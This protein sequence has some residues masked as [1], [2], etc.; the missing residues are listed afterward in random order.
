MLKNNF[1]TQM[2]K[3]SVGLALTFSLIAGLGTGRGTAAQ[4]ETKQHHHYK[5][6]D[7]GTF[8]GPASYVN[9]FFNTLNNQGTVVGNAETTIPQPPTTNGFPCPPGQVYKAFEWQ[10]GVVHNLG[11]L[12]DGNCSDTTAINALGQVVGT[13]ET[14]SVDPLTGFNEIRAVIWN[15]GQIQNLG[16]FGGNQSAGWTINNRGQVAGF[17]LND[18]P[19]PYSMFDLPILGSSNGTQTRA[20]ISHNGK[21]EDL[22]TL[23]GPDA[24][25]FYIND[26]GEVAGVSYT[27]ANPEGLTGVPEVHPF[28]W[29]NG[30]MK[31]LGSFG[32]AGIPF[33]TTSINGMNNRGQIIGALPL[34][35]DQTLDPFIWDGTKLV[36]MATQGTGGSFFDANVINDAGVVAG[37][38]VFSNRPNDAALWKDGVVTDLG[39]LPADCFSEAWSINTLGQVGGVS[40]SCDGSVWRAFLWEHGSMVDLNSLVP[41]GSTLSLV[42]AVGINDRGEIAG[43]GVLQGVSTAP[44]DQDTMSRAFLLIPCDEQHPN[45]EGCDYSPLDETSTSLSHVAQSRQ[46]TAGKTNTSAFSPSQVI[47]QL[48]SR[49]ANKHGRFSSLHPN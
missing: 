22:G 25:G 26:L 33:F 47:I 4:I 34:P 20:F 23:G 12:P 46:L 8:G 14:D 3:S 18:I 16:T 24:L 5:L 6:V 19:D 31:D 36:D 43:N 41:P 37:G 17:A 29:Q 42:Y 2:R 45:I 35:G 11:A 21:L 27:N 1:A 39:F 13:S 40:V 28:L 9:F 44:P 49:G 7:L 32:G 10:G 30:K 38:A 15:N 48:R